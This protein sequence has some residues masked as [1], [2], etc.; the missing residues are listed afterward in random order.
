MAD[1]AGAQQTIGR[2]PALIALAR[3]DRW[4]PVWSPAAALRGVRATLVV[5]GGFAFAVNVIGNLQVATFTAFGGFATLVLASFGGSRREKLLAHLALALAGSV[6]LTIGTAVTGTTA[7][8]ALVTF[9]VVFAVFFAGVAGPNAAGGVTAALLSYVLPAASPGTFSMVP[10]RLAGWWLASVA[11]TAAVL[12]ISP[13]PAPDPVRGAAAALARQ[14]ADTLEDALRGAAGDDHVSGFLAAKHELLAR[15]TASPYR[16]TGLTARDQSLANAVEL[17]EWCASMMTDAIRERA[18]LRA[19]SGSDRELLERAS[20]ALRGISRLLLDGEGAVDLAGLHAAHERSIEK[21]AAGG[22]RSREH[23]QLTFHANTIA[24]VVAAIGADAEVAA[25]RAPASWLEGARE[26]WYETPAARAAP[27][28]RRVREVA[29]EAR[30]HASVRSVWTINSV[31]GAAALAA[32]VLV[33]D[34]GSVQHG[35]WVVLGTLAVLRT[36]AFGTGS[37]ALRAIGGTALGFVVGGALLVAIGANSDVLW[38]V[39]PVA[40]FLAAYTPGT[41]PFALGQAAFTVTVAI[42]YNL[43][44]PVGWKVGV[45]RIEDVAIGCGVS[46]CVGALFWPRGVSSLV[47]NDLADAYRAGAAYLAQ[48]VQWAS[49]ARTVEP[50]AGPRAALSA[51]RL[52]G[53]LRAFL[54]EQGTKHIARHELWRLVGGTLRLRLTAHGV[55]DLPRGAIGDGQAPLVLEHRALTLSGWYE[56]LAEVVDHPRDHEPPPPLDP[57][58]LGPAITDSSPYAVWMCEHLDHLCEHLGELAE[59]AARIAEIRR[60]PW[61]R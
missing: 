13:R 16:P 14:L 47:G 49:G 33:A 12:L 53:A 22:P 21:L 24:V 41:A 56:R 6:L 7:L 43:L 51:S 50:D 20:A 8:A 40:V 44:A 17:L 18:D 39:L 30:A 23:S 2:L 19:A 38:A 28:V 55:T 34:L 35:F 4:L 32:A 37:T 11:G 45:L 1:A 61:W 57:P 58:S 46:V 26:R 54:S 3:R 36:S 5:A 15:F 10:D 52:D 42:L 48:A 59:P 60:R 9:A 31:R 27:A 29:A 25:S